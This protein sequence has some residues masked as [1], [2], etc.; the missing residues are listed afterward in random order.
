MPLHS[1]HHD[2]LH[3]NYRSKSIFRQLVFD[4]S[5]LPAAYPELNGLH[6]RHPPEDEA[7]ARSPGASF[8]SQGAASPGPLNPLAPVLQKGNLQ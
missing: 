5:R 1:L 4:E 3:L 7:E 2:Q 8:N 6:R